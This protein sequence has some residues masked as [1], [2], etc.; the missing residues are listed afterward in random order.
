MRR[1]REITSNGPAIKHCEFVYTLYLLIK[2]FILDDDIHS[3]K[4]PFYY[5]LLGMK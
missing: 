5:T 2:L 4:L 1:S 3:P